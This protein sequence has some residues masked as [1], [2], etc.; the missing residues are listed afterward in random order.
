MNVY[1]CIEQDLVYKGVQDCV[2]FKIWLISE[3]SSEVPTAAGTEYGVS[4]M[5][6][7]KG[8]NIMSFTP[9]PDVWIFFPH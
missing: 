4:G 3:L 5:E 9:A 2:P 1:L 7:L 8:R 6:Y